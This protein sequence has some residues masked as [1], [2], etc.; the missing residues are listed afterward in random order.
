MKKDR[1]PINRSTDQANLDEQQTTTINQ[2]SE[3]TNPKWSMKPIDQSTEEHT[4]KAR[5]LPGLIQWRSCFTQRS[6]IRIRR[7]R[8]GWIL[9]CVCG[10]EA[11][12]GIRSAGGPR[13][14]LLLWLLLLLLLLRRKSDR[15]TARL[16]MR[17]RQ[18]SLLCC[19]KNDCE[20]VNYIKIRDA[21]RKGK[22]NFVE[23]VDQA[24][25]VADIKW[26]LPFQLAYEAQQI[27]V[28]IGTNRFCKILTKIL[29][30]LMKK[31]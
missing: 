3:K 10:L 2:S 9:R 31:T 11:R 30:F 17:I 26:K 27:Q 23:W 13:I 20:S 6:I 29:S 28:C 19:R 21:S 18:H 12:T 25:I 15:R 22:R 7:S 24:A 16:L 4:A 8:L 5:L 14:P 1:P